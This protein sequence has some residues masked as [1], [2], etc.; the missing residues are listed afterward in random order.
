[1]ETKPRTMLVEALRRRKIS[2]PA[3]STEDHPTHQC[4]KMDE[5][6]LYLVQQPTILT[7]IFPPRHQKMVSSTTAPLQGGMT[8][9]LPQGCMIGPPPQGGVSLYA[10]GFMCEHLIN[11][12]T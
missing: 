2:S 9:P 12:Q 6:H 1:M 7:N 5:I 4:L 11:L 10:H 3:R 8:G